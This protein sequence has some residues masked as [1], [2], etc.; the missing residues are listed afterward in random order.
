MSSYSSIRK[1][2]INNKQYY[3]HTQIL[4]KMPF[5]DDCIKDNDEEINITLD[6]VD[7]DIV[8]DFIDCLYETIKSNKTKDAL[9]RFK[10][11]ILSD[12]FCIDIVK[13]ENI[14]KVNKKVLLDYAIQNNKIDQLAA[15]CKE[16]RI[17]YN[18]IY[19]CSID[20]EIINKLKY[21]YS[22]GEIN[23][24]LNTESLETILK[25]FETKSIENISCEHSVLNWFYLTEEALLNAIKSA[26]DD[27]LVIFCALISGILESNTKKMQQVIIDTVFIGNNSLCRIFYQ[28]KT[29]N[30]HHNTYSIE[31]LYDIYHIEKV[32]NNNQ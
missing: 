19:F 29:G 25:V 12:Y 2:S 1:I 30:I 7:D 20:F 17:E 23:H 27:V 22:I 18:L 10:L 5:F 6:N 24:I 26:K 32:E 31:K 13:D 15:Y 9:D 21:S 4:K 14:H 28:Y 3:L 11:F 8:V 16:N